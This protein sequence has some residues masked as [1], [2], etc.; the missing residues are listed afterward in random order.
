M[1]FLRTSWLYTRAMETSVIVI[2]S[3]TSARSLA[4]VVLF[5]SALLRLTSS[6]FL[7][8]SSILSASCDEEAHAL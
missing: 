4:T 2:D 8:S 7:G 5:C 1:R 3:R 6:R